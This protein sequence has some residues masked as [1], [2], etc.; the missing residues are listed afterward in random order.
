MLYDHIMMFYVFA[1]GTII[2]SFLNVVLYRTYSGRS[3]GG[4]SSCGSCG[5]TLQAIDL[6]PIV[7]F[8][9]LRGRCR[10]C[11][12]RISW[13]YPLVEALT[14]LLFLGSYMYARTSYELIGFIAFSIVAVL[15]SVY[16]IKHTIIPDA[17]SIAVTIIACGL[18][19]LHIMDGSAT[20]LTVLVGG[21]SVAEHP[22]GHGLGYL[23]CETVCA[24][25]DGRRCGR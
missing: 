23:V 24:G 17:W 15:I 20:V 3:I 11:G 2:G 10:R 6:V 9:F 19:I 16:D 5:K 14:G 13:Q 4:R 22:A 7:S 12:S 1:L 18:R 21:V 8:L 25:G